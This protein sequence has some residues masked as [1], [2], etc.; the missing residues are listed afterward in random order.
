MISAV[1]VYCIVKSPRRPSTVRAASGL[2]GAGPVT[3]H[4]IAPGVWLVAAAVPLAQ[5]GPAALESS[6]RDLE[7][8]SDIALAHE[9]I[10]EH[11]ARLRGS[12]VVPMKLFTMFSTMERAGAEM[13]RRR[14]ELARVFERIEG[15]EEWGVRVMRDGRTA[16]RGASAMPRARPESG[17]A[18]LAARKQARD[19]SRLALLAA[20]EAANV[21]FESLSG[22][23]R[24]GRRRS[25][26]VPAE[27]KPLLD[28]AFLVPARSRKRF[29]A[30]AE[31]LA[32]DVA[33]RG[34]QLTLTG[35]WPPYNFVGAEES[36]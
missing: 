22:I 5:Y 21:A 19:E 27:A 8:V 7:W 32:R 11:F 3:L 34:A 25:D 29:H 14:R 15:C 1:Y 6:L 23:A 35:P 12:T 28:A 24:D 33:L 26:D 2:P 10:V 4:E 13:K 9:A 20:A 31:R 36:R 17:A 16:A 18:F 30:L